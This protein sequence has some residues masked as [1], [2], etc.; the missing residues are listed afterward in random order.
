MSDLIIPKPD[1]MSDVRWEITK[2][3]LGGWLDNTFQTAFTGD[4]YTWNICEKHSM[5]ADDDGDCVECEDGCECMECCPEG[6]CSCAECD[7]P[8]DCE[9]EE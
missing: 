1:G 2:K 6:H 4:P 5:F 7:E 9:D 8:C 3:W